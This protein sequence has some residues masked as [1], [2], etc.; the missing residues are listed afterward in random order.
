MSDVLN[1][2][3]IDRRASARIE[4]EK[5]KRRGV[6]VKLRTSAKSGRPLRKNHRDRSIPLRP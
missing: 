4:S 3:L 1:V 5:S 2:A 6:G